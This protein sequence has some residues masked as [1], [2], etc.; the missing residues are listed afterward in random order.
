MTTT[1]H[2]SRHLATTTRP[3]DLLG[4]RLRAP[5]Y[6]AWRAQVQATGGCA[7]PIHLTGSSQVL[8]RDGAVLLERA[9]TV[10]A[11]CG[12]RR[13]AVCPACSDRYA[14]DAYHLLRAGL[15]GDDAK[16][17]PDTVTEHPRA[18]LT[19]T[20]PVV[21]AGAHPQR[22][23]PRARHPLP[24]RRPAPPRRPP[25]RHRRR[26]RH[27]RLRRARCCGRPTPARCGPGSPPPCAA[28]SPP[29][30]ASGARD[31]PH[32]AR[33]SYAKVA[34]YQR[35][36]LVHFHAV[37]RL[38]GPD[39]PTD[40]PPPG[41]TH[42]ALRD[43]ITTAARAA[44]A[45]HRPA[46]RHPARA[47]LG[48]PARPPPGHRDRRPPARG[49]RRARSPTPRWP[50]TS[51]STPPNPPAPS[52]AARARTGRSATASTSPTSTSPR[53]TAA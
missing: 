19:L 1:D 12:N 52:T 49:R 47:R 33:L 16:G 32:H 31:F 29:R 40:P 24:L 50:A 13:A 28:P 10:L 20:A 23:P 11:P 48:R 4:A 6:R 3:V 51:P 37:I 2:A 8:D 26:P 42:D 21:R 14:A 27:L 39:G 34:E 30:S 45:H 7:A 44:T 43:A 18:F 22:H 41:L 38:D 35:R 25:P 9:G 36:G 15:A 5:D 46:R 53:T 17:V